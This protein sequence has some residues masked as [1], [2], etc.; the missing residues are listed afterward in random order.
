MTARTVKDYEPGTELPEI[1]ITVLDLLETATTAA[2]VVYWVRHECCGRERKMTR[3]V[4]QQRFQRWVHT[5]FAVRAS[6]RNTLY[7]QR[8]ARQT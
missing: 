4:I 5:L 7:A 8:I 2:D 3:R 1:S 6:D